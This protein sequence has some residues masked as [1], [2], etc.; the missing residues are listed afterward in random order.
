MTFASGGADGL[1]NMWDGTLKKR[2][3]SF[4]RQQTSISSLSFSPDG[5]KLAIA[6]SYTFEEGEKEYVFHDKKPTDSVVSLH[7]T[8]VKFANVDSLPSHPPDTI[9]IRSITDADVRPKSAVKKSS[10]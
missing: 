5:S 8:P 10:T 2:I 7:R 1:V 3:R 6:V 9:L 4:P